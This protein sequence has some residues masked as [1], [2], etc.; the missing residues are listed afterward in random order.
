MILNRL[1]KNK[2]IIKSSYISK[3]V[4]HVSDLLFVYIYTQ[5]FF[6]QRPTGNTNKLDSSVKILYSFN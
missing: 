2:K 5:A 6:L 4:H 1:K 3:Y